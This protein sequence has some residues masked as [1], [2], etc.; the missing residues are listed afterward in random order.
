MNSWRI[1]QVALSQVARFLKAPREKLMHRIPFVVVLQPF[2]GLSQLQ[3][4]EHSCLQRRQRPE[5]CFVVVSAEEQRELTSFPVMKCLG[6]FYD[7]H[8]LLLQ[9][10]TVCAAW[11]QE[12]ED[13][14][15]LAK[16][17]FAVSLYNFTVWLVNSL[18]LLR[19]TSHLISWAQ[20]SFIALWIRLLIE[21]VYQQN[22]RHLNQAFLYLYCC[23]QSAQ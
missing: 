10:C 1:L 15:W 13:L 23:V 5:R 8:T 18:P 7:L 21:Y 22:E 16:R 20:T 2:G 6:F 4:L 17:T 19:I 9:S 12:T 11:L 14:F 3:L